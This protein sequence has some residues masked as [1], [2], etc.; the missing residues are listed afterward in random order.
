MTSTPSTT[1]WRFGGA[2]T[3]VLELAVTVPWSK[4]DLRGEPGTPALGT[5]ARAG[6]GEDVV[7]GLGLQGDIDRC[8]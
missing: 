7:G 6:A 2:H 8:D 5:T 3:Y 1:S 4:Q